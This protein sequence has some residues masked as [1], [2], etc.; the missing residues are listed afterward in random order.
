MQ[1][2][3]TCSYPLVFQ[4]SEDTLSLVVCGLARAVTLVFITLFTF[5]WKV[6]EIQKP[7]CLFFYV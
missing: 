3:V 1:G 4:G 5:L 7:C 2:L 6:G